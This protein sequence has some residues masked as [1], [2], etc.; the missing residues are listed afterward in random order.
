MN[1]QIKKM[2]SQ[3]FAIGL[4]ASMLTGCITTQ[5][6]TS[7]LH[8]NS[9]SFNSA[10]HTA[11]NIS[12]PDMRLSML[13]SLNAYDRQS[14]IKKQSAILYQT[15][16]YNP[17]QFKSASKEILLLLEGQPLH[18]RPYELQAISYLSGKLN[19]ESIQTSRV[20]QT[21]VDESCHELDPL[22]PSMSN[23]V[24][25]GEQ[26]L[27]VSC[28]NLL[29]QESEVASYRDFLD[30]VISFQHSNQPL[31]SYYVPGIEKHDFPSIALFE[32][33]LKDKAINLNNLMK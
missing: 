13:K 28:W 25:Q 8:D 1:T 9:Q 12:D 11:S 30:A 29:E 27:A 3:L 31:P 23:Y 16:L 5:E 21:A 18:K 15:L 19:G 20:V 6:N 33:R 26:Q 24:E 10:F 7:F 2:S 22:I 17:E 14:A 32:N 4:G